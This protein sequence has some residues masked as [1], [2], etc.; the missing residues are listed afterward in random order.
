MIE[1]ARQLLDGLIAELRSGTPGTFIREMDHAMRPIMVSGGDLSVWQKALSALRRLT[2]PYMGGEMLARV[3]DLWQQAQVMLSLAVQQVQTSETLQAQGQTQIVR[4]IGHALGSAFDMNQLM[5][6]VARELPR[7]GIPSC[8]L[9]LY[10]DPQTPAAWSRLIMAY[11]EKGRVELE[12]DGVRFK[13]CELLPDDLWP[14]EKQFCWVVEPLY[15]QKNSVGL[16][17]V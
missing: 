15:F 17:C 7:L 10:E 14:R 3:E 13:S 9:A 16:C 11:N 4:G 5:D 8:Y 6:T 12:P 1:W 2:L